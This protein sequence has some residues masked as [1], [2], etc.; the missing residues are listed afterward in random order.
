MY[1][2]TYIYI[3][4]LYIHVHIM[5]EYTYIHIYIYV[6]TCVHVHVSCACLYMH[7]CICLCLLV[8][9]CIY[10]YSALIARMI[11]RDCLEGP[12]SA[13]QDS[14]IVSVRTFNAVRESVLSGVF[15]LEVNIS[16]HSLLV[17]RSSFPCNHH[18]NDVL[19]RRPTDFRRGF[20]S[21]VI[22]G[23]S[24]LVNAFTSLAAACTHVIHSKLAAVF[25]STCPP[26][27]SK[28]VPISDICSGQRCTS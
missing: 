24:T 7:I 22:P 20:S 5:Y 26:L 19:P 9:L 1:V 17:Q 27:S 3:Y 10:T 15:T 23:M 16:F 8:C 11:I 14:Q 6:H 12:F 13:A 2:Y 21:I 28:C 4:I 25:Y 18:A